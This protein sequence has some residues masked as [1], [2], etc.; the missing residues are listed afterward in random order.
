MGADK[1]VQSSYLKKWASQILLHQSF[2]LNWAYFGDLISSTFKIS[3]L[4]KTV[5]L[6]FLKPIYWWLFLMWVFM[7]SLL[8]SLW[9]QCLHWNSLLLLWT[10]WMCLASLSL[11]ARILWQFAHFTFMLS[12][13]SALSSFDILQ[14][15]SWPAIVLPILSCP[16]IVQ[17][18]S[19]LSPC[20]FFM[21]LLILVTVAKHTWHWIFS[22]ECNNMCVFRVFWSE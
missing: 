4:I 6:F 21:C 15:F 14:I 9:S 17:V 13:Y 2:Q 7:L 20:L 12:L 5:S 16:Q 18:T 1:E 8:L 11:F 3:K 10:V 19:F 22:C